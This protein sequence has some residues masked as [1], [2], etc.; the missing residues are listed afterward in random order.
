[1][2]QKKK[3]SN[4]SRLFQINEQ[5]LSDLEQILPRMADWLS[6]PNMTNCQRVQIRRVQKI[7]SDVRWHYG[8]PGEMKIIPADSDHL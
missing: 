5:D 8:P 4:V 6:T 7:V 3:G 1:M 2:A